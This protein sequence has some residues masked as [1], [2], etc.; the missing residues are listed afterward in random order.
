MTQID[1]SR[2]AGAWGGAPTGT[3]CLSLRHAQRRMGFSWNVKRA[4]I[5]AWLSRLQSLRAAR[6]MRLEYGVDVN[7]RFLARAA[8]VVL[9]LLSVLA[10]GDDEKTPQTPSGPGAC[11]GLGPTKPPASCEV[12]LESPPVAAAK[13]VPEKTPITYCSN[14]PSGG[15]HYP[16]WAAFQEYT[17]PVEW[18]Y[19]VHSMEH[20]AVVLLYKCDGQA[21]PEIVQQLK[22]IRD[23]AAP[24]PLC[25]NGGK[26]IIIAPSTTILTKVAAAAWGKTY[27]AACVDAPTLSAFVRDN[28]AKGPEDL[29]NPGRTF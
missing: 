21:C 6:C 19:L 12:T 16:V 13:H 7:L 9:P 26:R 11:G 1:R 3:R 2:R 20:G 27:Q 18:P 10:C 8:F 14:P 25:D 24:D 28:Y 5:P 17:A 23:D 22:K 29:C 15:D 4:T